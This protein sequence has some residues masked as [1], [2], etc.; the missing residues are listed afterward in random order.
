MQAFS[1]T[2]LERRG[3]DL[4]FASGQSV[5]SELVILRRVAMNC[6]ELKLAARN[7][8]VTT[9]PIFVWRWAGE[10]QKRQVATSL[11]SAAATGNHCTQYTKPCDQTS[12]LDDFDEKS[13][14]KIWP[15]KMR[16]ISGPNRLA[17][18]WNKLEFNEFPQPYKYYER[19]GTWSFQASDTNFPLLG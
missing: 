13:R 19:S 14:C 11:Q 18:D 6:S 5:G 4:K 17:R 9:A 2:D 12:S 8:Q 15:D 3:P 16:I 10:S 1:S 7:L